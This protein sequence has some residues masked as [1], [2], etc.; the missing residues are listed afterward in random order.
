MPVG[1]ALAV[2]GAELQHRRSAQHR[3][4]NGKSHM[5][6]VGHDEKRQVNRPG[7]SA[8]RHGKASF[9]KALHQRLDADRTGQP[10]QRKLHPAEPRHFGR[11]QAQPPKRRGQK[12]MQKRMRFRYFPCAKA[13]ILPQNGGIVIHGVP[14]I[15]KKKNR[16]HQGRAHQKPGQPRNPRRLFLHAAS[17]PS[18]SL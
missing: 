14:K 5:A 1:I 7:S 6:G 4:R 11:G 12:R 3:R 15:P 2:D 16:R 13:H 18:I 10:E 17:I 9:G 8:R